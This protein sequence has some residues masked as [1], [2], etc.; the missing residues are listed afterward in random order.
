MCILSAA[1][2]CLFCIRFR[3]LDYVKTRDLSRLGNWN[4]G[5]FL[6]SVG[7]RRT[8][9]AAWVTTGIRRSFTSWLIDNSGRLQGAV[10][11]YRKHTPD[12]FYE[13]CSHIRIQQQWPLDHNHGPRCCAII[14]IRPRLSSDHSN[15]IFDTFPA[16]QKTILHKKPS[17]FH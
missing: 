5:L 2:L 7:S 16:W 11:F 4:V 8:F 1:N 13:R 12:R 3:N 14:Y 17:K 15:T 10:V 9:G 6:L